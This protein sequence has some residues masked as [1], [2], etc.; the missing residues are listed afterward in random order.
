MVEA[1]AVPRSHHASSK[2]LSR[3]RKLVLSVRVLLF[4]YKN[5]PTKSTFRHGKQNKED[6][7]RDREHRVLG[8]D[9]CPE[10]CSDSDSDAECK[11]AHEVNPSGCCEGDRGF[12]HLT[13]SRE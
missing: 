6:K 12:E 10:G 5:E 4:I 3:L 9:G 8:P 2:G 1:S 7:K 13:G 11:Q